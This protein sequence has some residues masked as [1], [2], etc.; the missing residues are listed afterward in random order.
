MTDIFNYF[1][2]LNFLS[3]SVIR[4]PWVIASVKGGVA[5]NQAFLPKL[6]ILLR[7]ISYAYILDR[8]EYDDKH[9]SFL[10]VLAP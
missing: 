1:D 4:T 9:I 8:P 3:S 10:S 5:R 2:V 6:Q 7:P